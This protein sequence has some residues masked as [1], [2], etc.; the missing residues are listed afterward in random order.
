[1]TVNQVN[2][3]SRK[4]FEEK[5]PAGRYGT[6]EDMA[7]VILFLASPLAAYVTGESILVDGGLSLIGGF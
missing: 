1:M 3:E 5:V 4:Y 7:G 2:D 6:P